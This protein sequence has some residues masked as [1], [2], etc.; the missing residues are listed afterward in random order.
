M[1]S[2]DRLIGL[3][4]ILLSLGVCL[5]SFRLQGG[6]LEIPSHMIFPLMLGL[7]LLIIS[8]VFF[9]QSKSSSLPSF[10]EFFTKGE[11][12]KI[13]YLLGIFFLCVLILEPMGFMVS[14]FALMF[15]LLIGIGGKTV[16]KSILYSL[17]ISLSTYLLFT[18]LLAV[19][20]PKGILWF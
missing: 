9:I 14:I 10:S 16:G 7:A 8:I 1:K 6:S 5:V 20:L 3:V 15:L 18:R 17:I 13:I 2:I 19:R 11:G 12:S 4:F